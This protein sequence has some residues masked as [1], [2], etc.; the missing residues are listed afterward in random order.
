MDAVGAANDE[1][2]AAGLSSATEPRAAPRSLS[3]RVVR[4]GAWSLAGRVGS[5]GSLF[6]LNVLLARTLS[7]ADLSAFM[8]AASFVTL[9]A[10]V[11]TM[12]V[13]M[14]LVR[15]VRTEAAAAGRRREAIVGALTLVCLGGALTAA[16]YWLGT[17]W[18]PNE[19]KWRVLRDLPAYVAAWCGL[20][21]LCM[22]CANFL[23]AEDDFRAATLVGA[24]SGGLIPNALTLAVAGLV[25]TA[26]MLT[27]DA[28]M[29]IQTATYSIALG[30]AGWF[31]VRKLNAPSAI[32][33]DSTTSPAAASYSAWWYLAESWPNLINQAIAVMLT[34][35]DQLWVTCLANESLA[36]HYGVI[37]NLRLLVA[38]PLLVA[39][40]ALPPFVAELYGRGDLRRMERLIRGAATVLSLPS[41]GALAV[42]LV[43]PSIVLRLIYGAEF[44]DAATALQIMSVGAA[45]FVLTGSNGMTLTMTGRHRSLLVCSLASLAFYAAISPPLVAR[46]GL[47][48]A[49]AAFALQTIIQN[50]IVTLR[51]KQTV[52][53]W[54]VPFT[55][56][57]ALRAE[58]QALLRR[59]GRNR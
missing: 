49:A 26:G 21:A 18:F 14:T 51:V 25:A 47:N 58:I 19:P 9:V 2:S 10:M 37:R 54:T 45:V 28:V 59:S 24:R 35:F 30:V 13:P 32:A 17:G 23:Q 11:A 31:I 42:M 15:V 52:G 39:S 22:V 7:D 53:I 44:A 27:L 5:M 38:A 8:A 3:Q 12:G 34:E 50:I 1:P 33:V 29:M 36:A 48:G 16:G 4:G 20:S 40:I 57:S 56:R 55:S 41:L 43:F 6:L 46:W